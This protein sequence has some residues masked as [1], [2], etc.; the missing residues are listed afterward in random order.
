MVFN[1]Y[2]SLL[3]IDN[4]A[5]AAFNVN[6]TNFWIGKVTPGTGHIGVDIWWPGGNGDYN[7]CQ[8]SEDIFYGAC[9]LSNS[10]RSSYYKVMSYTPSGTD[11]PYGIFI[12]NQNNNYCKTSSWC[13][14]KSANSFNHGWG[15]LISDGSIE[16]Y[17]HDANG[18]Y[19]PSGYDVGGVRVA[20][21]FFLFA[22]GGRYSKDIGN[23]TLPQIG[24][25]N[26][27][28]LNGFATIN[29]VNAANNRLLLEVFQESATRKT[30]TGHP[31]TG[32]T[33]VRNNSDGY[34]NSGAVPSG[35]YKMYITDTLTGRK[36]ILQGVNIF[37]LH[38]RLDFKLEQ[39]CFGYPSL[40][41][42]D[43]A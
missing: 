27:G 15:R 21:D 20:S 34:F 31:M 36:I 24:Q 39:R 7:P 23:I 4:R 3:A 37:Q 16:I 40:N 30:S 41:C 9:V 26:V 2:P 32:F 28:R 14:N 12:D 10:G 5:N 22:N 33:V 6:F 13:T 19:N 11:F 1:L 25:P 35:S 29:S 18:N 43:P 17:P 38:E 8:H 42:I